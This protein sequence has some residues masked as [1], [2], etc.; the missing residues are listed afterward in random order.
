MVK[1]DAE[2]KEPI[3][4][5]GVTYEYRKA[6]KRG[7]NELTVKLLN[8][9][10]SYPSLVVLNTDLQSVKVMK[11]FKDTACLKSELEALNL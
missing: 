9:K 4:F 8:G 7:V 5:S 2:H 11:G 1:L 6:A 3:S 10:L